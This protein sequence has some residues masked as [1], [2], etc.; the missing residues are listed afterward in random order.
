MK[1]TTRRG[2]IATMAAAATVVVVPANAADDVAS[3]TT[4]PVIALADECKGVLAE[5]VE[6]ARIFHALYDETCAAAGSAFDQAKR[7]WES[8]SPEQEATRQ[9]WIDEFRRQS[10]ASGYDKASDVFNRIERQLRKSVAR[11]VDT[12]A[13]TLWGVIGKL[14]VMLAVDHEWEDAETIE[15]YDEWVAIVRADIERL[16]GGVS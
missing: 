16:A 15:G 7:A 1:T 5:H 9:H 3:L 12:R 2:A 13:T 6:A 8:G 11:L 4:D 14:D 10:A